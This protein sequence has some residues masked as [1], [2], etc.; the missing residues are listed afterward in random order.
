MA[1]SEAST[2]LNAEYIVTLPEQVCNAFGKC[3][4]RLN[5]VRHIFSS[6]R[7]P[8]SN[9]VERSTRQLSRLFRVYC[10]EK[11][12]A[13]ALEIRNFSEFLNSVTHETTGFPARE[14]LRNEPPL[15]LVRNLISFSKPL[16][17]ERN[18]IFAKETLQGRVER[19]SINNPRRCLCFEEGDLVLLRAHPMSSSLTAE[20]KEFLL[21][22]EG[23]FRIKKRISS[24]TYVIVY[25]N[26]GKEGN[27][28]CFALETLL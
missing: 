24:N 13:S 10:S 7:H 14:L 26:S 22:F 15:P 2:C 25:S 23:P 16:D 27:V 19:P 8:Q 9:P 12:T 1:R 21:F 3:S 17:Y 5:S 4:Q 18:L 20:T 6:I 28:S 11:H